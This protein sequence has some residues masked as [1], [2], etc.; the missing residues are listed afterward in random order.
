MS[1]GE[2]L[3]GAVA[4]RFR[5]LST[6]GCRPDVRRTG[7]DKPKRKPKPYDENAVRERPR[8]RFIVSGASDSG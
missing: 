8:R 4:C 6:P 2:T 7:L 1:R 3:K 5:R